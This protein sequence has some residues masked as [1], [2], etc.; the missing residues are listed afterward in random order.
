MTLDQLRFF[1]EIVD[2]GF[3]ISRAADALRIA[4]PWVS[5]HIAALEQEVGTELLR[6]S[7]NRVN[8]LTESGEAVLGLARRVLCDTRAITRIGS[9]IAGRDVRLVIAT[10]HF[11]A[12]YLLPEVVK[13]FRRTY[14][15]VQLGLV[16]ANTDNM[17]EAVLSGAVDMGI[18]P[19]RGG[20][21]SG[22][23]QLSCCPLLR[24]VITPPRHPLLRRPSI[25]LIDLAR[26][27]IIS[28]DT[29]HISTLLLTRTFARAGV[30]PNVVINAPDTEVVKAYVKFGLGIAVIP[31]MAFDARRER[32]LRMIDAAHLF[33][34]SNIA[35]QLRPGPYIPQ[36]ICDFAGMLE[37]KWTPARIRDALLRG[38][39]PQA[40][41]L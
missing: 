39:A 11:V 38:S 18:G 15:N 19:E 8:G 34:P 29:T 25:T 40:R 41:A 31:K 5:R 37:P 6:R 7:R 10:T 30:R 9:D 13:N 20:D 35:I 4:Q 28:Y 24:G 33:E 27:P 36:H 26:Y 23:V 3:S 1:C 2:Q 12:G 14:P 21:D 22:L 16:Q 32:G 17:G